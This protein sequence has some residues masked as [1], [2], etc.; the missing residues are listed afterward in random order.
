LD[1]PG[2][3]LD[4]AVRSAGCGDGAKLAFRIETRARR[5]MPA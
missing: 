1:A 4:E 5:A 2:A 3:A